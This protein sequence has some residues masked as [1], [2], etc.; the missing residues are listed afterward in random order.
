[1]SAYAT[2]DTIPLGGYAVGDTL[3]VQFT[4]KNIPNIGLFTNEEDI[5]PVGAGGT[6]LFLQSSSNSTG[7]ESY[8]FSLVGPWLQDPGKTLYE[9]WN[10]GRP[11]ESGLG[12]NYELA[13]DSSY[14]NSGYEGS[15]F[16]L[17]NLQDGV[18]YQYSVSTEETMESDDKIIVD[19][20]LRKWKGYEWVTVKT[21]SWEVEHNLVS[22]AGRY[23]I[24][25]GL[26]T[27]TG[28]EGI[29]F[30][31]QIE[32][33]EGVQTD[34]EYLLH[35]YPGGVEMVTEE[36][37]R[38]YGEM[39]LNVL[40]LGSSPS[41]SLYSISATSNQNLYTILSDSSQQVIMMDNF[42][43]NLSMQTGDLTDGIARTIYDNGAYVETV[44]FTSQEEINEYVANR[45]AIYKNFPAFYGLRLKD[46]PTYQQF[47]ALGQVYRAI[48]ACMPECFVLVNL[49]PYYDSESSFAEN[50]ASLST[51][52]SYRAYL[53]GWIDASAANYLMTDSYPIRAL[54]SEQ[55]DHLFGLQIIAEICAQ[56][57]LQFH[58][59]TQSYKTGNYRNLTEADILWQ[60][61]LAMAFGADC[62]SYYRY[63]TPNDGGE[64]S[65]LV[66]N[67]GTTTVIY[68]AVKS[69]H[70]AM[71]EIA[72]ELLDYE[73]VK[74][75]VYGKTSS[76]HVSELK[77]STL[78][79]IVGATVNN[80][81]V[82]L[83]ITELTD[84]NGRTGYMIV[85]AVSTATMGLYSSN[86]TSLTA[87]VNLAFADGVSEYK[88][89]VNGALVSCQ[90]T[91]FT[92]GAGEAVFII[93]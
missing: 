84:G 38:T 60:I 45:M 19:A 59:V 40:L 10:T 79:H 8:T 25:Y 86:L 77:K 92:L 43:H 74:L 5:Q 14:E 52:Q 2:Y 56:R 28:I 85:N 11:Y 41:Y 51:E 76:S 24:L 65:A 6:G 1:M 20:T 34:K 78:T 48:K 30:Y 21:L 61:N 66:G 31:Y 3:T 63:S 88:K 47:T 67:D 55:T 42:L 4:G 37:R 12:K 64:I 93:I 89:I 29:E 16:G 23:A 80:T 82:S 18:T 58:L 83:V 36:N 91:S 9:S 54:L 68:D 35:A 62:I 17:F 46:E 22:L 87:T 50:Y 53:N 57:N 72:P 49:L 73:Y 39:G 13:C 7:V 71:Q 90:N 32:H 15:Y 75:N 44:C 69:M 70:S 27:E 33:A 81:K 26:S